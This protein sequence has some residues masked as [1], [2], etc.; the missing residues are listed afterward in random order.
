VPRR[1]ALF[2]PGLV[3][4]GQHERERQSVVIYLRDGT[5]AI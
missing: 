2:L 1:M 3:D 5:V 4:R